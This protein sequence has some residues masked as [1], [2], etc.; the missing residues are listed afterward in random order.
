[1]LTYSRWGFLAAMV[2]MASIACGGAVRSSKT[3]D[4]NA[5]AAG[6][7]SDAAAPPACSDPGPDGGTDANPP[8]CIADGDSTVPYETDAQFDAL[9]VGRWI[10]CA[11]EP[12]AEGEEVGVEF[13]ADHFFYPLRHGAN[14]AIERVEGDGSDGGQPWV[15]GTNYDGPTVV[16]SGGSF[17]ISAPHFYSGGQKMV[18]VYA[19]W[20]AT[21]TRE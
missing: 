7:E 1:M 8:A 9:V 5:A 21:Y 18:L 11:G 14:G 4:T 20:G 2:S 3:D 12:Q 19:P 15:L 6:L 10:R 16:F 17:T 13:T